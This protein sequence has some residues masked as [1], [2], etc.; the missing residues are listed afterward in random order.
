MKLFIKHFLICSFFVC[1]FFV[2]LVFSIDCGLP[3]SNT[4]DDLNAPTGLIITDYLKGDHITIQF[5]CYNYEVNF[6]G[7]NIYIA[8]EKDTSSLRTIA[9]NHTNLDSEIGE[10]TED[11][12]I[13][14]N[15][16][17][18]VN[19]SDKQIPTIPTD[20]L[21]EP[22]SN[23]PS[24]GNLYDK[25]VGCYIDCSKDKGLDSNIEI[26]EINN[27]DVNVIP[28]GCSIL[29][30]LN[31]LCKYE[32]EPFTYE[33]TI[34]NDSNDNIGLPNGMSLELGENYKIVVTAYDN[35]Y[36]VESDSSNEVFTSKYVG[37]TSE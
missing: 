37:S 34:N 29:P 10:F 32:L 18:K 3:S 27:G 4:Y 33:F 2:L 13:R 30:E 24:T 7:Y 23:I 25:T 8:N 35:E 22:Y 5:S 17:I 26:G 14:N 11:I 15:Y 20:K 6:T 19:D 9:S 31:R 12:E 36:L 16:I 21:K 28:N 1:F